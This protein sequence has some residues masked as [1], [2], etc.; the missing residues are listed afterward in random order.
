MCNPSE[1]ALRRLRQRIFSYPEERQAQADR[2]LAY[3]KARTLRQR[4]TQVEEPKGPYSGLTQA[5]LRES[6]TCE[7]D[8]Y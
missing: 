3:L 8:W 2:V 7:T 5:E 6:G 1:L 4:Q